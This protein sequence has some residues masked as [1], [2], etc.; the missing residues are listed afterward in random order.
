MALASLGVA[1][2]TDHMSDEKLPGVEYSG[3]QI[4]DPELA[5]EFAKLKGFFAPQ[6]SAIGL[7]VTRIERSKAWSEIDWREDLVGDVETGVIAGGV[8][9][10]MLDSTCGA[11]TQAAL[12][13]LTAMA[14]LD[15]RIDYMRPAEPQRVIHCMA[16]CYKTT[17]SVCFV[18]GVA[19]HDNPDDPIAT[20][21]G[22]FMMTGEESYGSPDV[23]VA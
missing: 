21:A 23:V 15:L 12:G 14:T 5:A 13:K 16:H 2:E 9:T 4:D 6:T 10:T 8:L 18:R 17:R 7:R 11:A 3:A 19:Y 20:A 22:T 1:P